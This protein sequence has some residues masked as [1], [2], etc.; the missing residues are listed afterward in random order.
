MKFTIV[1]V[2]PIYA[3]NVGACSRAMANM[4]VERLVIIDRKCELN[5]HARQ[6]AATGQFALRNL[7]E[8]SNWD[9][10][11]DKEGDGIR[12]A[13]SAREGRIRKVTELGPTLNKLKNEKTYDEQAQCY[14]FFGPE[15]CGLSTED[16][17]WCHHV[18]YIPT[19]GDNFSLNIAQA[20]LITLYQMRHS[21]GGGEARHV[22]QD[23][24]S[25]RKTYFPDET[26]K[27]WLTDLGF[28]I[29]GRRINVHSVFRKMLLQNSPTRKELN[30]LETILQQNIRKL[31][32]Y[33]KYV[34]KYGPLDGSEKTELEPS[35]SF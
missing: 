33:Q 30:T 20:V 22:D 12:I 21:W 5:H 26:I 34:E 17:K 27:H 19:F 25:I 23:G 14:F 6:A 28:E 13:L 11:Y 15:D 7:I 2:R 10:F 24:P 4:G 31:N 1:L 35:K 9:E 29:E 16:L 18:C 32:E 8:Y 3:S